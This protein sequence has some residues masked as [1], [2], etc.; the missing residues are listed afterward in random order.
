[1]GK[2]WGTRTTYHTAKRFFQRIPEMAVLGLEPERRFDWRV[3]VMNSPINEK[4]KRGSA[5][6]SS[7]TRTSTAHYLNHFL[8][9]NVARICFRVVDSTVHAKQWITWKVAVALLP[10][11]KGAQFLCGFTGDIACSSRRTA[12]VPLYLKIKAIW[13]AAVIGCIR[14]IYIQNWKTQESANE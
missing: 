2:G 7:S 1:M 5:S 10:Q 6:R 3:C 14:R 4:R 12:P 8:C 11:V 9:E 13:V